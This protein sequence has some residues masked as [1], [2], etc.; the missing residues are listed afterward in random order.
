MTQNDGTVSRTAGT[1]MFPSI[2]NFENGSAVTICAR[3]ISRSCMEALRM[4]TLTDENLS[5]LCRDTSKGRTIGVERTA[6]IWAMETH[7]NKCKMTVG[8]GSHS[9]WEQGS[10]IDGTNKTP[11]SHRGVA[12]SNLHICR[13]QHKI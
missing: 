4:V 8:R 7:G 5:T 9:T 6:A 2:V 12:S 13:E 3:G 1:D 11:D 10:E